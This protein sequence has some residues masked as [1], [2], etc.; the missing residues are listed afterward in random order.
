MQQRPFLRSLRLDNSSNLFIIDI[1]ILGFADSL[2]KSI[3]IQIRIKKAKAALGK[4]D[5]KAR[6]WYIQFGKI[7]GAALEKLMILEA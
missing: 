3:L 5:T 6:A 4:W 2:P 7:K 1:F